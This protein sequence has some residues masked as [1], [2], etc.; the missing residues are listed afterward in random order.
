MFTFKT[1]IA[2]SPIHGTGCFTSEFIPKGAIIWKFQENFDVIISEEQLNKF[3]DIAKEFVLFYGYLSTEEG[4]YI[5][6]TDNAKYTNHSSNPNMRMINLTDSIATKDIQVGEE[7]TED[8]YVF[9]ENAE[10]KLS[11]QK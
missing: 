5:L 9:D 1:H 8:Y 11:K 7:I 6:C 2:Q 4:G 10:K 3:P